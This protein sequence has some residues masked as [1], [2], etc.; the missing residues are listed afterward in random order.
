MGK[1]FNPQEYMGTWSAYA[2]TS[3]PDIAIKFS[4]N[5]EIV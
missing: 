3:R 1:A 4:V 2:Y 5:P